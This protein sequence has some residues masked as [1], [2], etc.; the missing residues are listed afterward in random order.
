[1][2]ASGTIFEESDLVFER[3][4]LYCLKID[5]SR[6]GLFSQLGAV[7]SILKICHNKQLVPYIVL[8][9][10][11]YLSEKH[12]ENVMEY[13]F[14]RKHPLSSEQKRL[15]KSIPIREVG[16]YVQ[17]PGLIGTPVPTLAEGHRL[18]FL[19]YSLNLQIVDEVEIFRSKYFKAGRTL[20]LHIRGTDKTSE[21]TPINIPSII[22]TVRRYLENHR[23][24]HQ[25]F[26]ATDVSGL[27]EVFTKVF[28][29][30][31]VIW[32]AEEKRSYDKVPLH[33]S[34]SSD[35]YVK[36]KD[37]IIN[38]L[39]LS[40]CDILFKTMSNL[41]GWAKVLNPDIVVRL[42]NEPAQDG[43]KWLGFP[44]RE[45]IESGWFTE[46]DEKF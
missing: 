16:E 43:L 23:D 21:A 11:L 19:Y 32:R 42:L 20:G 13:F 39:I 34:R 44:E 29:F 36:G 31:T 24:I 1:M 5:R 25:I 40:K 6:D 10:E 7:I 22:S 27:P 41:S 9:N 35:P 4:G 17:I 3:V 33:Y 8:R 14:T 46:R 15:I 30:A 12:G 18:F 37:A 45:M 2:E 26:I 28:S 38:C